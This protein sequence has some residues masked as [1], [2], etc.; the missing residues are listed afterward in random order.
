MPMRT[1]PFVLP[2]LTTPEGEPTSGGQ[3]QLAAL[4]LSHA[5]RAA[6]DTVVLGRSQRP[7]QAGS[8]TQHP[9]APACPAAQTTAAPESPGGMQPGTPTGGASS[10]RGQ[11]GASSNSEEAAPAGDSDSLEAPLLV[12]QGHE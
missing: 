9:H 12:R 11:R 6:A 10:A 8:L 3:E 2:P 5:I 4:A 7:G 1:P